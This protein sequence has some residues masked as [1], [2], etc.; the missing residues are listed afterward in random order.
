MTKLPDQIITASTANAIPMYIFL[1][2]DK[3]IIKNNDEDS[4]KKMKWRGYTS[5]IAQTVVFDFFT[6]I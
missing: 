4:F 1:R 3:G 5:A 2:E 6:L